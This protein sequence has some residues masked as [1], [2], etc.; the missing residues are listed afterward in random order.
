MISLPRDEQASMLKI[1]AGVGDD[2][3]N[4]KPQLAAAYKIV[5]D[6]AR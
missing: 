1:V 5:T 2:V 6:A 4:A 3:S